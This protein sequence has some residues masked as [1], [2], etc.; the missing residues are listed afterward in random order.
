MIY[1]GIYLINIIHGVGIIERVDVFVE[2]LLYVFVKICE[3]MELSAYIVY[4]LIT[5]L[6]VVRA[7]EDKGNDGNKRSIL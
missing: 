7:A 1:I 3:P 2:L 5:G 4:I 6:S